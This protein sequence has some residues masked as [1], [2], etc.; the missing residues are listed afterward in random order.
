MKVLMCGFYHESNTFSPI[1]T[2]KEDFQ[3]ATGEELKEYFTGAVKAFEESDVEIITSW[4]SGMMS[5]GVIEEEALEFYTNRIVEDVR[6]HKD[7]IDGIWVMLHG[8]I[9]AENIGSGELYILRAI[10]KVIGFDIP[11]AVAHDP[12]G[13]IS[14]DETEYANIIRAYHTA[15]HVDQQDTYYI[16]AKA[17]VDFMNRKVKIKPAF[18]RLPMLLCGDT[19]LTRDEP[20]RSVIMRC[21]ELE[22]S[23]KFATA[24]VQIS[25]H[26]ANTENT[27]PAVIITPR[28]MKYYDEAFAL[29]KELAHYIYDRR[30]QFRFEAQIVDPDVAVE[31]ALNTTAYPAVM[32]DSGD[33]TTAGATG[34]STVMLRKFLECQ[35]NGRLGNK[36]VLIS[37]LFDKKAYEYL[38]GFSIGDE[39]S[40]TVGTAI[41]NT[42]VP[43]TLNGVIK[44]KGDILTYMPI[45]KDNRTISNNVTV[46]VGNIDITVT[47]IADSLTSMVEFEKSNLDKDEYDIVVIKQAYQF[48]EMVEYAK[49][50]IMA[51]TPGATYQD[52]PKLYYSKLPWS[53]WPFEK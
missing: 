21:K 26:S 38:N 16:T 41:D 3:S 46:S 47:P 13:N 40:F 52:L 12:H 6:A 8:A 28:D 43:V 20:L 53:I 32:S 22:K 39:V 51:L 35:N 14:P 23:D 37:T 25:M 31:Q 27:Y 34:M 19:A 15:P 17:L 42:A 48:P 50:Q 29:A 18:M 30:D 49:T 7:E 2:K 36:K 11:L 24:S 33:N 44:A 5:T 10:R 1:K 9:Y 4:F 45:R